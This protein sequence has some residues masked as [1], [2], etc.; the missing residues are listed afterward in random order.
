MLK[1]VTDPKGRSVG[2]NGVPTGA[3]QPVASQ[4]RVEETIPG[5]GQY[6]FEAYK[7]SLEPKPAPVQISAAEEAHNARQAQVERWRAEEQQRQRDIIKRDEEIRAYNARVI[8]DRK[9]AKDKEA[10]R[11]L[12]EGMIQSVF[13]QFNC[14]AE[15]REKIA[16]LVASLTP[17]L[18]NDPSAYDLK[19]RQYRAAMEI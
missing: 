19:V 8:S 6:G 17:N 18:V 10:E 9:A 14:S 15:E 1:R 16:K 7:R 5:A 13:D 4:P 3:A 12:A 11:L 2:F